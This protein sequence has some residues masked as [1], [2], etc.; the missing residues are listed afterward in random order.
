MKNKKLAQD[1]YYYVSPLEIRHYLL[2]IPVTKSKYQYNAVKFALRSLYPGNEETTSIDY[3]I[4]KESIIGIAVNSERIKTP[5][6]KNKKQSTSVIIYRTNSIQ[7]L[8]VFYK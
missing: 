4:S 1:K 8:T 7:I 6:L 3:L 2:D 5:C